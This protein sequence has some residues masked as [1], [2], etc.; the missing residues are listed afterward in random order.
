MLDQTNDSIGHTIDCRPAWNKCRLN[1]CLGVSVHS[2][3]TYPAPDRGL[4]YTSPLRHH[5]R[6]CLPECHRRAYPDFINDK[7]HVLRQVE[8]GHFQQQRIAE[9]CVATCTVHL[10]QRQT[11]T[12]ATTTTTTTTTRNNYNS[13]SMSWDR[14]KSETSN[15]SA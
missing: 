7:L 3:L 1:H 4:T 13:Y 12:T 10:S 5:Q 6:A 9:K 14:Q 11:T 8:V 2:T 15:S